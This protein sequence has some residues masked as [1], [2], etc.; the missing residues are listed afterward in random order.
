[1]IIMKRL[2]IGIV[3]CL[4]IASCIVILPITSTV[5][6]RLGE[7]DGILTCSVTKKQSS[8]TTS[9]VIWDKETFAA[10]YSLAQTV[11]ATFHGADPHMEYPLEET[12]Y[13][14]YLEH[15][16]GES[17]LLVLTEGN[18]LFYHG[19]RYTLDSNALFS[20]F[21]RACLSPVPRNETR[22]QVC[23]PLHGAERIFSPPFVLSFGNQCSVLFM[24]R[25]QK[26]CA[27]FWGFPVT[28][29][30]VLSLLKG[31]NISV[32][33]AAVLLLDLRGHPPITYS[34]KRQICAPYYNLDTIPPSILSFSLF[35]CTLYK[36]R[37]K[38]SNHLQIKSIS[39][40]SRQIR[41]Y[42]H[43]EMFA[44]PPLVRTSE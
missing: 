9:P 42:P 7:T 14:L 21:E 28:N 29:S 17:D 2:I 13:T 8:Q 26:L 4:L 23:I 31:K 44:H 34:E 38:G 33:S 25:S 10:F 6:N 32:P 18:L 35:S 41:P 5:A 3:V 27:T 22:W 24:E 40:A 37:K 19:L 43:K 36:A 15:P 30:S 16:Q 12:S 20:F 11:N 39:S 1:M